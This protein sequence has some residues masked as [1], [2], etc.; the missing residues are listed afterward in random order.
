MDQ[1]TATAATESKPAGNRYGRTEWAGAFGDLGTLIPFVLAYTTLLHL[2]P[3]G[4]L[5]GF[6]LALI[7]NGFIYRT[8]VPVQPMKAIGTAATTQ[9]LYGYPVTA[10]AVY[11][12]GV[13]TG[14]VW[15]LL[16]VTGLAH[17][18]AR[19]TPKPVVGGL[20]F[21]LGVKFMLDGLGL[22]ASNVWLAVAALM[23][24]V[25]LQR[26]RHFPAMFALLL[27]GIGAALFTRPDLGPWLATLR[28]ALH[29]PSWH[30]GDVTA[31][32]WLAGAVLLA[33]PQLPLT[34]GNAV[35]AIT[36]EH[37]RLFPEQPV[38]ERRIALST[39]V[40]NLLAPAVGGVPMCHGAGGLAGHV[41]FGARTGGSLVILGAL[42]LILAL[43]FGSTLTPLLQVIPEAILGV[44]LMLAGLGL[45]HAVVPRAFNNPGQATLLLTALLTFWHVGAAFLAGL[46]IHAV[47]RRLTSR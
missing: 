4:M 27:L 23:L 6:G 39:G 34:L 43:F 13:V 33:V 30:L 7:A 47:E 36:A 28:P 22:M 1:G 9:A 21:G 31:T 14:L 40:M 29:L 32:E 11:A 46:L 2:D 37:N 5:V 18:L 26:N 19:I 24:A 35:I 20:V 44:I 45:A 12:A 8:P 42:L 15:I 17:R 41:R 10:G 16:S 3:A 25:V 38:S